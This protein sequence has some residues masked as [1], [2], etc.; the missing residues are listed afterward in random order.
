[1]FLK[2]KTLDLITQN[3][4]WQYRTRSRNSWVPQIR[5]PH[6]LPSK[7]IKRF[8]RK[9]RERIVYSLTT[10]VN[11]KSVFLVNFFAAVTNQSCHPAPPILHLAGRSWW[12]GILLDQDPSVPLWM[13][14][15]CHVVDTVP[16]KISPL[17]Q[18]CHK[19]SSL[20]LTFVKNPDTQ[21]LCPDLWE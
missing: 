17:S 6:Q 2:A 14:W 13:G 12:P 20:R 15:R 1:M 8:S 11:F 3:E 10:L 5:A 18:Y 21:T 7:D 19:G 16:P 4:R 9:M